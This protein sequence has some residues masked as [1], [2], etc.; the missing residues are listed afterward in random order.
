MISE[1]DV[2]A[3]SALLALEWNYC[4]PKL[5]KNIFK[6]CNGRHPVLEQIIYEK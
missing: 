6:V 5:I 2:G 3:S 1:L 4:K